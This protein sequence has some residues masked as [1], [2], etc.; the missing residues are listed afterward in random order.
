MLLKTQCCSWRVWTLN[1][2]QIQEHGALQRQQ[3]MTCMWTDIVLKT[4]CEVCSHLSVTSIFLLTLKPKPEWRTLM[5]AE[6]PTLPDLTHFRLPPIVNHQLVFKI[7][8]FPYWDLTNFYFLN[9]L[10]ILPLLNLVNKTML[11]CVGITI[12]SRK[13][14]QSK[15]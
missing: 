4:S 6:G 9:V 2:S 5:N 13:L 14:S 11:N 12:H 15:W 8:L 1:T 10:S 3:Q 7:K